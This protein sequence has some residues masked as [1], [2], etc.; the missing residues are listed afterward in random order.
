MGKPMDDGVREV[1]VFAIIIP[2]ITITIVIITTIITFIGSGVLDTC[3]IVRMWRSR[4]NLN[5]LAVS[6]PYG[7]HRSNS[8]HQVWWQAPLAKEPSCWAN[9]STHFN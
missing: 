5:E 8:D 7:F 9:N 4:D 2:A 6:P 3:A 1:T